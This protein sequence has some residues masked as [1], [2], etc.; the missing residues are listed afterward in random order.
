MTLMGWLG[1]KK[2]NVKNKQNQSL[3]I[4]LTFNGLNTDG[5]FTMA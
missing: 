3:D 2:K 5:L 4:Q 1:T